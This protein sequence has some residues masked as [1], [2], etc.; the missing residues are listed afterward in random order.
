M[1]RVGTTAERYDATTVWLHWITV[2]L[3]VVL[4]VI[5]QTGD[6]VPRGPFRTGVWSTHVV[7]GFVVRS[8]SVLIY[9][10]PERSWASIA[11]SYLSCMSLRR[12]LFEGTKD[13]GIAIV[14]V[15]IRGDCC[16]FPLPMTPR[17]F[18]PPWS[19]DRFIRSKPHRAIL[20]P[21]Q[22]LIGR[23]SQETSTET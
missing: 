12:E 6:L 1:S 19:E 20:G 7:L 3:I 8:W 22:Q 4:W 21:N 16:P 17:R 23:I 5:G 2:A 18:P 13:A 14:V 11:A 10:R 9:P 15:A